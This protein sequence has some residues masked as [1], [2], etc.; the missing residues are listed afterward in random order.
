[1]KITR[2][3]Y[4]FWCERKARTSW[5]PKNPYDPGKLEISVHSL[6]PLFDK[7]DNDYCCQNTLA[8]IKRKLQRNNNLNQ[9]LYEMLTIEG[10]HPSMYSKR[11]MAFLKKWM[12]RIYN[13]R[14]K[15]LTEHLKDLKEKIDGR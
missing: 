1:M 13:N 2:Q 9:I 5:Q 7:L 6:I 15:R 12:K 8:L 3:H 10:I 4:I 14:D 11:R